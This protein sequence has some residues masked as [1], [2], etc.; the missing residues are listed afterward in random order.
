M[1]KIKI[2][3]PIYNDWKSA[4]K[5]LE[6]INLQV[7]D[8]KHEFSIIIVN[9]CSTEVRPIYDFNFKNL[10][11][12]K[13][14]NMK[15]N[16]GHA[17]CNAS[18]LRY[19]AEHEDYD[20][21]IP[22]DGD[23]EDRA[24]EITLLID[25]VNDYPDNV[26]TANRIKRSEGFFFKLCYFLHKYLTFVFTGKSIKF[27]NF[28]CLPKSAVNKMIKEK[29]TWSSF[30]GAVTKLFKNRKSIPSIRGKRFFG[31]SKM[32]FINLFKHSL[33]IIAVFKITLLIRSII[34]LIVYLFIISSNLSLITFLPVIGI[35][36]MMILV[37]IL[38]QRENIIEFENYLENIS[39]VDQ[40]K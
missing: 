1:S 19:I 33:S 24:E 13:I 12:I 2:L 11:S 3:I 8:L 23:G 29:S 4:F 7:N 25:K 31:P 9:D 5:L 26:V 17:R 36:I 40:L 27:G 39:S 20:Y 30:S 6:D 32:S 21:I 37:I 38:S 35:I 22:M 15:R 34:F 14:I 16:K 28:I 18:G 10:K